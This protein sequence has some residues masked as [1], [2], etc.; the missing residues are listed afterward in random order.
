MA[1]IILAMGYYGLKQTSILFSE[2][3][4]S[5]VLQNESDESNDSSSI[6]AVIPKENRLRVDL[7]Q[8]L[9]VRMKQLVKKRLESI[10]CRVFLKV[11][12]K[13]LCS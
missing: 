2:L 12:H 13:K 7:A 6:T 11:R 3:E 4:R 5:L 1:I 9:I 8:W 10:S